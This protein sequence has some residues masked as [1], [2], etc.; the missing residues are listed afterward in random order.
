MPFCTNCGQEVPE[1]AKF[2]RNCGVATNADVPSKQEDRKQTYAGEIRKCP[3]CGEP[4][5][6]F[7]VECHACGFEL[8]NAKSSAAIQEFYNK[9]V[10]IEAGRSSR[11]PGETEKSIASII[12]NYPIPNTKEDVLEFMMLAAS[13]IDTSIYSVHG[14]RKLSEEYQAQ[15]IVNDA[16]CATAEQVYHKAE[17]T[18]GEEQYF[19]KIKEIYN[20]KIK[21][22]TSEKRKAALQKI[23]SK[24]ENPSNKKDSSNIVF[25]AAIGF[26]VFIFV[27]VFGGAERSHK[28]KEAQLESIVTEIQ[29]CIANGDY[30]S[31][32]IK[33]QSLYMDDNWSSESREHWD[34]VREEL[35]SLIE[36]KSGISYK[37]KKSAE[38]SA[39]SQI[40]NP[41]PKQQNDST[42][43]TASDESESIFGESIQDVKD[44]FG[45][46]KDA[47]GEVADLYKETFAEM[48]G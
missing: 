1:G 4:L 35:I 47:Y 44:A 2:C 5:S 14:S 15:K 10:Q 22:I 11:K 32:Y 19:L 33:A 28:Q 18:F 16:W 29:T 6:A 20:Q 17:L 46:V 25:L 41:D 45:E 36:T 8:R 30:D 38:T 9:I 34:K 31:A 43:N 39:E 7:E 26:L 13:N 24:N 37:S 12:R 23:F 3:N 40:S 42:S 21:N 48:F 27:G